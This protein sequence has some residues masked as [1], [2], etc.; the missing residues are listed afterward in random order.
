VELKA[1]PA[2]CFCSPSYKDY[3]TTT[4]QAF[5][6]IHESEPIDDDFLRHLDSTN[7]LINGSFPLIVV[8][9][10]FGMRG[11]D[12]RASTLGITLFNYAS[13]DNMREAMQ[14]LC[15]V[16]RFGDHFKIYMVEGTPLIDKQKSLDYD[17]KLMKFCDEAATNKVTMSA[18]LG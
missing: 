2:I 4:S 8:T 18:N 15:R 3:I 13:Y 9:T 16:G 10:Q 5:T 14:G 17:I 7:H 11:I 6:H 12:Y 1:R